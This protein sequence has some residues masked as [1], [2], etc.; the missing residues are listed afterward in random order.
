MVSPHLRLAGGEESSWSPE[1]SKAGG[2]RDLGLHAR[3]YE[4]GVRVLCD[5]CRVIYPSTRAVLGWAAL[6][7]G[8]CGGPRPQLIQGQDSKISK[9][10]G[11]KRKSASAR[12]SLSPAVVVAAAWSTR[13]SPSPSELPRSIRDHP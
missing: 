2:A 7:A 5:S 4:S 12:S 6:A 3:G 11:A 1:A 10:L 13:P 9:R 8:L